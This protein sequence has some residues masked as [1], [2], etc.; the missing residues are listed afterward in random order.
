MRGASSRSSGAANGSSDRNGAG[1]E[2]GLD[3]VDTQGPCVTQ[4]ALPRMAISSPEASDV[5]Q[6]VRQD[7][8]LNGADT[9]GMNCITLDEVGSLLQ[10]GQAASVDLA[11]G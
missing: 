11:L 4:R 1:V 6:M 8:R 9:G 2:A 7:T 5:L 10:L 3:D